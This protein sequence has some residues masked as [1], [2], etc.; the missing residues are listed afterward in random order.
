[1]NEEMKRGLKAFCIAI[2]LFMTLTAISMAYTHDPP[3]DTDLYYVNDWAFE[4]E[5]KENQTNLIR[6]TDDILNLRVN[7]TNR[8]LKLIF[9]FER[10]GNYN[11]FTDHSWFIFNACDMGRYISSDG[12]TYDAVDRTAWGSY[13][14]VYKEGNHSIEYPRSPLHRITETNFTTTIEINMNDRM[15]EN[16]T[17]GDTTTLFI[18]VVLP[19]SHV[20]SYCRSDAASVDSVK[21]FTIIVERIG[22]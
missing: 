12:V 7:E 16:M 8:E 22:D 9:D 21:T 17:I 5:L 3:P 4:V 14:Y 19:A 1:M 2:V 15:V 11:Q 20:V 18:N 10:V 13:D 6:M